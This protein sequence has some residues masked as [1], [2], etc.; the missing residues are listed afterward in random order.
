MKDWGE[1]TLEDLGNLPDDAAGQ[2][3]LKTVGIKEF[4]TST[5]QRLRDLL[6]WLGT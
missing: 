5:E 2:T 3:V 4:D 1:V 6:K